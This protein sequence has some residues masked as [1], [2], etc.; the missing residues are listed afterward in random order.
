MNFKCARAGKRKHST[1]FDRAVTAPFN[2]VR[3]GNA[4]Q[5][6][7]FGR[8]A[9]SR[10]LLAHSDFAQCSVITTFKRSPLSALTVDDS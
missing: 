2:A 9:I 7:Y 3:I 1:R 8:A 10:V 6:K 5:Q 4:F